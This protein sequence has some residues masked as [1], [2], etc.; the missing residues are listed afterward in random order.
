MSAV[1]LHA[2]DFNKTDREG[3]WHSLAV[4]AGHLLNTEAS[5]R[6]KPR[7]KTQ[8]FRYFIIFTVCVFTRTKIVLS[9]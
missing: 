7:D 4:F 3:L 1:C 9:L 8:L 5:C 2:V 6:K